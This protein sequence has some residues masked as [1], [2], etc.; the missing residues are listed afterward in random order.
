MRSETRLVKHKILILGPLDSLLRSCKL[1]FCFRC[2]SKQIQQSQGCGETS[3]VVGMGTFS[4]EPFW[5]VGLLLGIS[6]K[7]MIVYE[8]TYTQESH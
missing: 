5:I 4:G 3:T 8:E 2:G 7:K 1:G 6:L